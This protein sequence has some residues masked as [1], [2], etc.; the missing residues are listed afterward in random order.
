MIK[1]LSMGF[2]IFLAF[3]IISSIIF[4]I[5]S[6]GM[7][8]DYRDSKE[9]IGDLVDLETM[10]N[11]SDLEI[12]VKEIDVIIKN[13]SSFRVST[14]NKRIECVNKGSK[15][16]ISQKGHNFNKYMGE[17]V[18]Y[19][20]DNYVFNNIYLN[21]GAGK[22]DVE[23]INAKDIDLNLGAGKVYINEINASNEASIDGG[24]GEIVIDSGRISNLDLDMGAGKLTLSAYLEGNNDIDAGVGA[25]NLNLYG[26]DDDYKFILDKGIGTAKYN[27]IEMKSDTYY[28]NGKTMVSID[29]GVGSIIINTDA[30]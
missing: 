2:A 3:S 16:Y 13:G 18:I 17:L 9:D 1:Y 25:I 15:L 8:F 29:G 27:G 20:P 10:N 5:T 4:G 14:N 26:T 28:G 21:S 12:D 30:R 6:L 23:E 19:I 24:A 11:V 22:I 7:I